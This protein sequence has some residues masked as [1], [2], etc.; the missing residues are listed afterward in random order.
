MAQGSHRTTW[1]EVDLGAIAR[2]L[3]H[4]RAA[5][6]PAGVMAMVK[7]DA[8]GHG[9]D[10]VAPHIEPL[11][12]YF[13]VALPEEG[14]HLRERGL[15]NPILVAGGVLPDQLPLLLRH[16]LTVTATSIDLL[17]ALDQ[18]AAALQVR[19]RTHLKI[20]TGMERLG[21]REYEAEAFVQASLECQHIEVEGIFTHLA[22]AERLDG[23]YSRMQLDRFEAV[24]SIYEKRGLPRPRLRHVCNSGGIL[25]LPEGYMELVRPGL[26]MYGIYPLDEPAPSIRVERALSWHSRVVLSKIT[27]PGRPVSYGST[28]KPDRETR[29]L[30]LPC[31]YGDGYSRRMS[32]R[33]QVS[34]NGRLYP[35]V[36]TICMDQCMVNVGDASIGAGETATLLGE[37]ITAENLAEWAGTNTYEVLTSINARVPRVAVGV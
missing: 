37:S 8:Y 16:D 1:L 31:G 11:V 5:V 33:S 22:N 3:Q 17:K 24:L 18:A 9:I 20:D 13:G 12:E 7:A 36:G 27:R 19:A 10:L 26:L 23:E 25:H 30:T 15:K 32:G 6:A 34:I 4:I 35:Q 29:L 28:W 21:V 2:N 14:I